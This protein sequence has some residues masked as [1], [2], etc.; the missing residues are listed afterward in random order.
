MLLSHGRQQVN[1]EYL[2]RAIQPD[3]ERT[4]N[5]VFILYANH[6]FFLFLLAP[7]LANDWKCLTSHSAAVDSHHRSQCC[8]QTSFQG[9]I[10]QRYLWS[11]HELLL[12]I[13]SAGL[14]WNYG[15]IV[16][17]VSTRHELKYISRDLWKVNLELGGV[18]GTLI[19]MCYYS[20]WSYLYHGV[21]CIRYWDT[22]EAS[23][24]WGGLW[25]A[26]TDDIIPMWKVGSTRWHFTLH[27]LDGWSIFISLH[28][29]HQ[30]NEPFMQQQIISVESHIQY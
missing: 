8:C 10:H 17:R 14:C 6:P 11:H 2:S 22:H 19:S 4:P 28:V 5:F 21:S 23:T 25:I 7:P 18:T 9:T 30:V 20:W 26:S 12:H 15:S 1:N 3:K 13:V 27:V 29:S 24:P 16:D